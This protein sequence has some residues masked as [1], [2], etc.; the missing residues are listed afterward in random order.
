MGYTAKMP[1]S[2][3]GLDLKKTRRE[4]IKSGA[5]V[6]AVARKLGVPVQDLRLVTYKLPE[7][8][9]AA[10]EAE[11]QRLD[12]AEAELRRALKSPDMARR[13]KAAGDI[14]RKSPAAKRRGFG[15]RGP[16]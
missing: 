8:I 12:E 4:L 11:E 3:A 13:L 16:R 5:N 15:W 1:A 2:C 9:E 6:S 10:L 14:L 7:L